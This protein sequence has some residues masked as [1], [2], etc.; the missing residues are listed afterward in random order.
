MAWI[1]DTIVYC[2]QAG[3]VRVNLVDGSAETGGQPC[4]AV[5]SLGGAV[6][7]NGPQFPEQQFTSY[8]SFEDV[9]ADDPLGTFQVDP[10]AEVFAEN[11][12]TLFAAWH[13]TSFIERF[14]LATEQQ[15][16]DLVLEG[17]D[18]WIRGMSIVG[19]RL[20]LHDGF[21]LREFDRDS[22]AAVQGF[23]LEGMRE[24]LA[25]RAGG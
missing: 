11:E 24:G 8:L 10:W 15:L 17:Y 18:D 23:E 21:I 9:L 20:F 1:D 19:S 16:P 4:S 13:S 12:A 2:D 14:D 6:L 7:V 22:G 25:C 3:V 5:T